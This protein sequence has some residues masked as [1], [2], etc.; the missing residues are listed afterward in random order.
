MNFKTSMRALVSLSKSLACR[1]Q[2][3]VLKLYI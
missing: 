2:V 3:R 1:L